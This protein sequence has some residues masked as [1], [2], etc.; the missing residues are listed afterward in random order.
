[1]VQIGQ[2]FQSISEKYQVSDIDESGDTKYYGFVD[3][4]ESWYIMEWD[5]STNTFRYIKGSGN[6]A[7]NWS[8]RSSLTYDYYFNTF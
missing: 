2:S 8:D 3:K 4:S 1:M 5:T 7:T 6:Y